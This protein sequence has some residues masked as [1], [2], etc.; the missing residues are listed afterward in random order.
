VIYI[1][2][3]SVD[4]VQ[5]SIA[6]SYACTN[7]VDSPQWRNRLDQ[8]LIPHQ[9]SPSNPDLDNHTGIR[10]DEVVGVEVCSMFDPSG[11]QMIS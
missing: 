7:L 9:L 4:R 11:N 8:E 5:G 1:T 3:L 2:Q 10:V 6:A